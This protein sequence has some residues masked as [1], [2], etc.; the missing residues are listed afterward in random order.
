MCVC[1]FFARRSTQPLLT[2]E[3][4]FLYK[5]RELHSGRREQQHF[6][7]T[8]CDSLCFTDGVRRRAR[9]ACVQLTIRSALDPRLGRNSLAALILLHTRYYLLLFHSSYYSLDLHRLRFI[10]LGA[11]TET[12]FYPLA[13]PPRDETHSDQIPSLARKVSP[14][15][16]MSHIQA[17]KSLRAQTKLRA[18]FKT[19]HPGREQYIPLVMLDSADI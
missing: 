15:G 16:F 18:E 17:A 9:G 5:S 11:D 10:C 4:R 3:R 8:V 1:A 14:L 7:S 13:A 12:I 19:H 6:L 2:S